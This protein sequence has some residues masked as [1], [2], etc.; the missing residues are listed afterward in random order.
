MAETIEDLQLGEL[1]LIQDTDAFRFGTDAVLL[2]DFAK[3]L[4]SKRTL[5]LC[6]GNGIVPILLSHKT[7]T[8]QICGLEI[9]PGAYSLA[10]RSVALN[11]LEE[12][13]S[14]TLGDLKQAEQFYEVR[15]FDVIT[16]NP[17]YMKKGAAIAN[18][19]DAKTIARHEVMCSLEDI[20]RTSARLLK[21][22][23]HLVMVHRPNR[24]AEVISLMREYRIE[25]KRLRMIHP[26]VTAEPTLFLIDGLLYGGSELRIMPPLI[27]CGQDGGES[28]ELK[29][30]YGRR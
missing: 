27:L 21:Q 23:G 10:C 8:P 17:P 9:Q 25:P 6:C 5:D 1:K 3:T 12:R 26:S 30:I 7:K 14:I 2:S 19:T 24:M 29:Q 11:R 4:A 22:G 18:E 20:I 28:E 13:I 15:S 16:C